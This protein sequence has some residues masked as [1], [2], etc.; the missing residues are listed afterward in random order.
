MAYNIGGNNYFKLRDVAYILA[1]TQ[2]QFAVDWDAAANA[3]TL[4]AGAPY[5]PVGGELASDAAGNKT[6]TPTASRVLLDGRE[7]SLAAYNIAGNNYFKLRDIGEV[8]DFEIDWN[9]ETDTIV[10]DTSARYTAD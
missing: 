4:T 8:F 10:I 7:V 3:I 1:G 6:P 2:K 5:V 9:D